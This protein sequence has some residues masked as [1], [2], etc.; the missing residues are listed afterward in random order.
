METKTEQELYREL[1]RVVRRINK[2]RLTRDALLIRIK[3]ARE[4]LHPIVTGSKR[5]DI[6]Q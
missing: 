4:L 3:V 6:W 5:K 1:L 2:L